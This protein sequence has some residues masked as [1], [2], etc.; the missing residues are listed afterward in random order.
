MVKTLFE[1]NAHHF[2]D[3]NGIINEQAQRQDEGAKAN[4]MQINT[5]FIH[6]YKGGGHDDRNGKGHHDARSN[7]KGRKAD[8]QYDGDG[9][10]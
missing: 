8:E 7:A 10:E 6:Q 5:I 9:F 1:L 4:F 3:D 2:H